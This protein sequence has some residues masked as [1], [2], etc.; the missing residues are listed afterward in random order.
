MM[1]TELRKRSRKRE[2]VM[3][4]SKTEVMVGT[5]AGKNGKYMGKT[6]GG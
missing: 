4:E 6:D 5:D 3:G 1:K 2:K